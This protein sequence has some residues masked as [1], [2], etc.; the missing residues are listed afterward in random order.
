M[1]EASPI[2]QPD[3]APEGF[4][5]V[6]KDRVKTA[7]LGNICRACDW[8]SSCQDPATDFSRPEHRC[9]SV[10]V[11][12]QATGRTVARPDRASVV[13]QRIPPRST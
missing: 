3:V 1:P 4:I 7:R 6:A 11:I 10:P 12:H 13:F 5:A 2:V 8:R 9:M